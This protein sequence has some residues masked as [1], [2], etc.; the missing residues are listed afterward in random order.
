MWITVTEGTF[1]WP[2]WWLARSKFKI[3]IFIVKKS[4]KS[5]YI[6]L[7]FLFVSSSVGS[8]PLFSTLKNL[9]VREIYPIKIR[10]KNLPVR[11]R[12]KAGTRQG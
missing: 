6:D 5:S 7:P 12:A 3:Q 11:I 10:A 1:H 8:C 2:C 9:P 4:T